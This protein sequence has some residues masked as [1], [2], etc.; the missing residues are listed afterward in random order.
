MLL[1][2]LQQRD[3]LVGVLITSSAKLIAKVHY[4]LTT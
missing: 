3:D 1:L 2:L 4:F